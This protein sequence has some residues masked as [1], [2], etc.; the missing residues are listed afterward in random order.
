[1]MQ[2]KSNVKN[3][4]RVILFQI[5][6]ILALL[7]V[8]QVLELEYKTTIWS[9][10]KEVTI[11]DD[12]AFVLRPIDPIAEKQEQPKVQMKQEVASVF[13]PSTLIKLVSDLFK[14]QDTKVIEPSGPLPSLIKPISVLPV[15]D[16]SNLVHI[17][18]DEM[19]EFPGGETA[20]SEYI[21]TQFYIPEKLF[22]YAKEVSLVVQF[23]VNKMGDVVDIHVLKCSHPGL[24][25][26]Q[27]A[28]RLYQN[29]PPWKAGKH[30]G[31][32]VIT[33]LTQ[34]I[35]IAIYD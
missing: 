28:I 6:I 4:D 15:V 29:M 25:A 5:G 21:S 19:P 10:P 26:E 17:F 3:P 1:M 31:N 33:K 9:P 18:V 34:P 13:D 20:L 16:S 14:V 12:T 35:K 27:E 23:K 30:R 7:F 8:N 2:S 24:G 22:N 11:F 32:A